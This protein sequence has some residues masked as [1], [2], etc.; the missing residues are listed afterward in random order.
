MKSLT[1]QM[2]DAMG[3]HV[4]LDD[5]IWHGLRLFLIHHLRFALE[6]PLNGARR[7]IQNTLD[8]T[9]EN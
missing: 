1:E 3:P 6:E 4:Y 9:Q 2:N 8:N 5:P 7:E